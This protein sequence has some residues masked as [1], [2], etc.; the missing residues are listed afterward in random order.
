MGQA[1]FLNGRPPTRGLTWLALSS[2]AVLQA[3]TIVSDSGGGGTASWV[4]AGT[5]PCRIDP[6]TKRPMSTQTAGAIDERSTHVC[7]LP[8]TVTVDPANRIV[9]S[10]RGT[11]EVTG[12]RQRTGAFTSV[13]EVIQIF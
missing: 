13:C 1:T 9:I 4:A 2:T 8:P 11:F 3:S 5:F 6:L 7:T 12:V 10:G